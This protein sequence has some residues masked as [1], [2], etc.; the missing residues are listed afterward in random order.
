MS[1]QS[2]LSTTVADFVN[3]HGTALTI[4]AG[5]RVFTAG[6]YDVATFV[7]SGNAITG[8]AL[9]FPVR[10]KDQ[11]E[12]RYLAEGKLTLQD[13]RVYVASGLNI[14]MDA[15]IVFNAGSYVPV[16]IEQWDVQGAKVYTKFWVR[17]VRP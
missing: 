13:K 7:T 10:G 6:D 4:Q 15:T 9:I 5:S 2:E 12:A 3:Q 16:Q 11:S 1:F 17:S 8:S 14:S